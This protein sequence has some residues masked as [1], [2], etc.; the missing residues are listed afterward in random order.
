VFSTKACYENALGWLDRGRKTLHPDSDGAAE[1]K[2]FLEEYCFP[3]KLQE[4]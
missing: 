4:K 1:I 3:T 2:I